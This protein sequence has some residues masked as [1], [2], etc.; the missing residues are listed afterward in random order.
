MASEAKSN[1]RL[2][3]MFV[4]ALMALKRIGLSTSSTPPFTCLT[5]GIGGGGSE[6]LDVVHSTPSNWR[7]I[8]SASLAMAL[9]FAGG[10][11]LVM[12]RAKGPVSMSSG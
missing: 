6:V 2:Y 8:F 10:S 4:L 1:F 12:L 11:S 9:A 5:A 7:K 3:T